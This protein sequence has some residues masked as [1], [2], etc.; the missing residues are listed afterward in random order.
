MV[1]LD[2]IK[3]RIDNGLLDIGLLQEPVDIAKYSFARTSFKERWGIL[4][5]ESCN[6]SK[7]I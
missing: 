6:L 5:N 1:I 4:V 3:E 7:K 2:N